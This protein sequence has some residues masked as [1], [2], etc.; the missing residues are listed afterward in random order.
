MLLALTT[1]GAE[2]MSR[3]LELLNDLGLLIF[4]VGGL[5]RTYMN[6]SL[7][8]LSLRGQ[9]SG[10]TEQRYIRLVKE[11]GAPKWPLIVTVT[12][13]PLGIIVMFGSIV[14]N[15]ITRGR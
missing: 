1:Q 7:D 3:N 12:L 14:W 11:K 9:L 2:V 4:C 15:N 13:I 5:A 10:N 6:H 8:G